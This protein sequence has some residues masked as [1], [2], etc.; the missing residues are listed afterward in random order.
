MLCNI[1]LS[2]CKFLYETN[3]VMLSST[4]VVQIH[5]S[6]PNERPITNHLRDF[7]PDLENH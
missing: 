3:L 6:V 2:G 1:I 7:V 5:D 4:Q